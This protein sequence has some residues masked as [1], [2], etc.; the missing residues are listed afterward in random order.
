MN[1]IDVIGQQVALWN[2]ENKCGLCWEYVPSG[3]ADYFNNIKLRDDRECCVYLAVLGVRTRSGLI[4]EGEFISK[5]YC[6]WQVRLFAGIP[7]RLDIQFYNENL[8]HSEDEGKW[9]KYLQPI[10]ECVGCSNC[11]E[12][13]LCEIHNCLGQT[14]VE[15]V[16]WSADMKLNYQ[17][18]NMDGV[19]VEATFREYFN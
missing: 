9:E 6:D 16:S 4:Q 2:T 8:M 15:P 18:F 10:F 3:R 14:T 19:F 1:V 5:R 11:V 12:L 13:D 17:D 7:S